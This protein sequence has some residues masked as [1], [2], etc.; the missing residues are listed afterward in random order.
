LLS[1]HPCTLRVRPPNDKQHPRKKE[2]NEHDT[3]RTPSHN[4]L[5]TI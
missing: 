4:V 2:R 1:R 5:M 3:H